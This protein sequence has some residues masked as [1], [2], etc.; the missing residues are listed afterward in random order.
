VAL[1]ALNFLLARTLSRSDLIGFALQ[2]QFSCQGQSGG[3]CPAGRLLT[4]LGC[5]WVVVVRLHWLDVI[6]NSDRTLGKDTGFQARSGTDLVVSQY[7][8]QLLDT[9]LEV[10][11][12]REKM[13]GPKNGQRK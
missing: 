4:G 3:I 6:L 5:L 8:K 10:K 11:G 7:V 9:P 12:A 1:L 2:G 13:S